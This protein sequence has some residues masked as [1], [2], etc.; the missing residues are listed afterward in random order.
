MSDTPY[1]DLHMHTYYSDGRF[2]PEEIVRHAAS[3]GLKAIAITD[4]ENAHGSRAARP[5]AQQSDLELIPAIELTS[6][7]HGY[8]SSGQG[9]DVDIL[10]YFIDLDDAD[11]LRH[12]RAA[13]DDFQARIAE[14]CALLT[15]AG[16][17]VTLEDALAENEGRFAGGV[18]VIRALHR[19]GYA[20]SFDA[21]RPLY[22]A[23]WAN[24]RLSHFTVVHNI[25]LI[26]AAGGVAVLAHPAI[27]TPVAEEREG[28]WFAESDLAQLIE[29]S[30]DGIEIYHYRLDD[31]ARAHFMALAKHFNLLTSGGSDEH[32]WQGFKRL[33]TEPITREIVVALR[34]KSRL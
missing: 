20:D 21:A 2:S 14:C 13:Q 10:G 3:I 7:W 29:M 26:H 24:V 18:Q 11:F 5:I 22:Y 31:S 25:N 32:G 12:E 6:R 1:A 17:P 27:I 16:Y 8:R 30:L 9:V 33:G 19:K 34:N 15:Q 23:Q 28:E 4:H